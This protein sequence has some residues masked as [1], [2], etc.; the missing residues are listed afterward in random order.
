VYMAQ[1]DRRIKV[2]GLFTTVDEDTD[3]V[4]YTCVPVR[5]AQA[6]AKLSHSRCTSSASRQDA[7]PAIARTCA[8]LCSWTQRYPQASG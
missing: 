8:A 3:T 7:H 4:A 5:L 2:V 1:R 6:Q